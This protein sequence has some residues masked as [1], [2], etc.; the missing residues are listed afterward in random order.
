MHRSDD[1]FLFQK[2][3]QRILFLVTPISIIV[4]PFKIE[5]VIDKHA[6]A[7]DVN[8]MRAIGVGLNIAFG[9]AAKKRGA[10]ACRAAAKSPWQAILPARHV[11]RS[12]GDFRKPSERHMLR[13]NALQRVRPKPYGLFVFIYQ[14]LDLDIA[15][16][17]MAGR[18][19][20]PQAVT[21]VPNKVHMHGRLNHSIS[22]TASAN[23]ANAVYV[24]G[25]YGPVNRKNMYT[26]GISDHCISPKKCRIP[27]I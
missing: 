17:C 10:C 27:N 14:N 4:I 18:P 9:Q 26:S 1:L 20:N 2:G 22:E 19:H 25:T 16:K 24:C 11:V 7:G 21:M 5:D 12:K 8:S 3:I 15:S 6:A 23:K 13:A